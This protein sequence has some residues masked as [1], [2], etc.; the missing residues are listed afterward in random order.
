MKLI[1]ILICLIVYSFSQE[2]TPEPSIDYLL[3]DEI[4]INYMLEDEKQIVEP[5]QTHVKEDVIYPCNNNQTNIDL[6]NST[7][8]CIK[9]YMKP[10]NSSSINT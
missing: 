9:F 1:H 8:D 10:I 4:N 6:N 5:L 7:T 3:D 2:E